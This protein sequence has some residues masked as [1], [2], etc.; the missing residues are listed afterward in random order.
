MCHYYEHYLLLRTSERKKI[1]WFTPCFGCKTHQIAPHGQAGVAVALRGAAEMPLCSTA[2]IL[3]GPAG[4]RQDGPERLEPK[5]S[6]Y[7]EQT[8]GW[9]RKISL[10]VLPTHPG[11]EQNREAMMVKPQSVH[12]VNAPTFAHL[13][14]H[15]Q[16]TFQTVVVTPPSL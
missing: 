11:D 15:H 7:Q 4:A 16:G 1:F 12:M 9:P 13:L 14:I 10:L 2:P 3:R 6:F 8:C 5:G